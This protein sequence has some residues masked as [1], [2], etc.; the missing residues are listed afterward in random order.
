VEVVV[1]TVVVGSGSVMWIEKRI[2]RGGVWR[3]MRWG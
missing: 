1:S 3:G 2:G